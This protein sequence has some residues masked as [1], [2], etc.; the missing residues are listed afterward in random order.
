[1]RKWTLCEHIVRLCFSFS[2]TFFC[3]MVS[4]AKCPSVAVLYIFLGQASFFSRYVCTLFSFAFA[5]FRSLLSPQNGVFLGCEWRRRPP[6]VETSANILNE[7]SRS[8]DKGLCF[9]WGDGS[10]PINPNSKKL[11]CYELLR[12]ASDFDAL[13]WA[14]QWTLLLP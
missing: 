12:S 2:S 3:L 9:R 14:R 13:L 5:L 11:A 7:Q 6:D 1:M 8:A 4:G 10:W